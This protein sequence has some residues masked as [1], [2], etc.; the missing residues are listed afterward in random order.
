LDHLEYHDLL[1]Q[2]VELKGELSYVRKKKKAL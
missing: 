2:I 1:D